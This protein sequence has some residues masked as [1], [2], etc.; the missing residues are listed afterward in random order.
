MI[1]LVQFQ[2]DL[3]SLQRLL[4]GVMPRFGVEDHI[5]CF[6]LFYIGIAEGAIA[7]VTFTCIQFV[8][9]VT[10]QSHLGDGRVQFAL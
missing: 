10:I 2:I 8:S 7:K 9:S 1:L 6:D 3:E 4:G 5:G